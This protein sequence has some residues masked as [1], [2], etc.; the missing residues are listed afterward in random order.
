MTRLLLPMAQSSTVRFNGGAGNDTLVYAGNSSARNVTLTSVGAT[1]GFNGTAS[2]IANGFSNIN[3]LVGGNGSDIPTG[4]NANSE[5]RMASGNSGA[6]ISANTLTFS[7][8]ENLA[9]GSGADTTA[10]QRI[11]PV[12][13]ST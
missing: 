6:Y 1:D 9:G 11:Q 12:S 13:S 3:A 7:A 10:T 4:L 8:I 2:G 5:W